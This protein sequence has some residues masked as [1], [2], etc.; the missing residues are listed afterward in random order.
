[1][2]R[3]LTRDLI[4]DPEIIFPA[5][6]VKVPAAVVY[7]N[8][9][10]IGLRH[11]LNVMTQRTYLP[12]RAPFDPV[13]IGCLPDDT[14]LLGGNSYWVEVAG[15]LAAEQINPLTPDVAATFTALRDLPFPTEIID[16]P[17]LLV[18]RYGDVTWGHWVAEI[19]PRAILAEHAY[20]GRFLYAV[21]AH[22]TSAAAVGSYAGRILES[23]AAYGIGEDRILKLRL[24]RHYQ[25]S[26]L[27]AVTGIWSAG[28]MN[29]LVMRVMR[30]ALSPPSSHSNGR[31]AMLRRDAPTRN[32]VN[33]DEMVEVMTSHNFTIVDMADQPFLNQVA[34]FRDSHTIFGVLGSGLIGLIYAPEGVKVASVAPGAWEDTYFHP[35]IQLRN[36]W[37]AD[38]RGPTL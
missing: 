6:T 9:A 7:S 27:H 35:L 14:R 31:L 28:G 17:C 32:L 21:G 16:A 1:V 19:L 36:G 38:L 26:K 29:P 34:L 24:D 25:F 11:F 22:V 13:M 4:R 3:L 20:P 37:H 2:Q 5:H 10:E 8:A 33:G 23:L 18:A 12:Y 30:E 15:S